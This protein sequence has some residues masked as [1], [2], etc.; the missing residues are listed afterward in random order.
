MGNVKF[1]VASHFPLRT[2]CFVAK[3]ETRG[4]NFIEFLEN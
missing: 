1:S 4:A 3:T 2:L